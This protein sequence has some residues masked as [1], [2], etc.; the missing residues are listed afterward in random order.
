M[1]HQI[2][3]ELSIKPNQAEAV[4]ELLQEGATIP[5][6]ARYRKE[7]TGSLDE[8]AIQ[9]VRD[10]FEYLTELFERK[11][12]V[13]SSMQE[14][15]KWTPE[16]AQAVSAATTKQQVEDLYAPFKPKRRTRAQ[17]AREMGLEPLADLLQ[18]QADPTQ[19]L[20][21]LSQEEP[22]KAL[23]LAEML[24]RA[25]DILAE[26]IS[27]RPDTKE[28]I[29]QLAWSQG[30]L[31]SKAKPEW[32]AQK[33]KFGQYYDFQEPIAKLPAH[34]FLAMRRGEEEG[35]LRLDLVLPEPEILTLLQTTW[36]NPQK[37]GGEL[38]KAITESWNRLLGPS[39]EVDLRL[40][41]KTR[42]D[43][44]S[45]QVFGLNLKELLLAAPAGEVTVLGLDPGLRTG[46]KYALIDKTGKLVRQGTLYTVA[47]KG[48]LAE[49]LKELQFLLDK[50]QPRF[51]A[52]GNG[53]GSREL[54]T[55]VRGL[56]LGN[57]Q[58]VMVNEAGASVYSASAIAREEFPDLDVSLRGAV[59]IARR[60]QDP[61]AELVKIDPKSIGVGQYQHD[62]HQPLLQR[63]LDEVVESCVN[64]VGVEINTA[65]APLLARVAG[66]GPSL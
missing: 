21:R 48:Q 41:L 3:K 66:V 47:S 24:E 7:K 54:M 45:I 52:I 11:T 61:L 22:T 8:V 46:S 59:S 50:E 53:T 58:P 30:V 64:S 51:I 49:S 9:A 29:R 20:A 60:L 17:I 15:G 34:R 5:F 12:A 63:K 57:A 36:L 2:A 40:E 43:E 56:N 39:I 18:A 27:E 44:E 16:F 4:V 14:L 55:L 26:R 33:S 35:V 37:P 13:L 19:E 42:S 25:R 6:I 31:M 65:S 23:P 1:I 38:E 62:V 32:A 10:R 28:R